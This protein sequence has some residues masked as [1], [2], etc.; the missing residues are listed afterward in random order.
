MTK[1]KKTEL[2]CSNKKLR[3]IVGMP[4]KQALKKPREALSSE[5]T[6]FISRSPFFIVSSCDD[7][8]V[9]EIS[10]RG[11]E[12]GFVQV[13]DDK[14]F[15]FAEKPGNRRLDTLSNLV[16]NGN[17][18]ILF[19]VPKEQYCLRVVGKAKLSCQQISDDIKIDINTPTI[20]VTTLIE[21][22]FFQ[23]ARAIKASRIWIA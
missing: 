7:N 15:L 11:D 22:V 19:L 4:S 17:I 2:L 3:E 1:S 21:K 6:D 8:G 23:C 20:F 18:G 13:L 12:P 10:P 16:S 14:A 9:C 5:H